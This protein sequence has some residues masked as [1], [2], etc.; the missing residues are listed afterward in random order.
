[1]STQGSG[2]EEEVVGSSCSVSW[3]IAALLLLLC[4][5]CLEWFVSQSPCHSM[6]TGS[7]ALGGIAP[8]GLMAVGICRGG[9]HGHAS[10]TSRLCQ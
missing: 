7:R 5:V 9:C 1:M 2:E 10:S 6:Q 4:L 8:V 3:S